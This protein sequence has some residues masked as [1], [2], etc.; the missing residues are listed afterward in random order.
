MQRHDVYTTLH[1]R[2]DN[3]NATLYKRHVPAGNKPFLT[4]KMIFSHISIKNSLQVF[5]IS[6]SASRF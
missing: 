6:A 3:V 4:K 2:R 5:I 1:E